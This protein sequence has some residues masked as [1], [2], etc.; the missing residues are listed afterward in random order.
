MINYFKFLCISLATLKLTTSTLFYSPSHMHCLYTNFTTSKE[1]VVLIMCNF[2]IIE[3][4]KTVTGNIHMHKI[5]S[6]L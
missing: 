6:S 4:G 3:R 1:T 5:K 2:C